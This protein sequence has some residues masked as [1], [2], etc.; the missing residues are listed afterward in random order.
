MIAFISGKL[1]HKEAAYVII[2]AAG[3]G[4]QINISLHTF[5]QLKNEE[6]CKLFT[7]LHIKEDAH[8]LYGFSTE[9]EKNTFRH[10]I[11]INGVGPSTALTVLSTLAPAELQQAIVAEDVKTI[12]QVKGIG[13]KSAQRI[14]L[15][16][17]DKLKKE[18]L[19][20]NDLQLNDHIS[21]NSMRD[22]ALTALTTLGINKAAAEKSID[23]IIRKE[24]P[25][26]GLEDL[27]KLALKSA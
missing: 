12:Q 25:E 5:S 26:I 2:E 3:I 22:E 15:E 23:R 7:H 27:I 24:G 4:Y 6:Q 14:V 17:K 21:H 8:T 10:L 20:G 1:A 19:S 16:L 13:A 9:S 18:N 11:S